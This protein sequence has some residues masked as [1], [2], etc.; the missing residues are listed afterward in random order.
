MFYKAQEKAGDMQELKM[1]LDELLDFVSLH[2]QKDCLHMYHQLMGLKRY[3]MSMPENAEV[4]KLLKYLEE[5]E[6][7]IGE[8]RV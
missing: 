1:L 4:K 5:G 3:L 8:K 2:T 7:A 6:K